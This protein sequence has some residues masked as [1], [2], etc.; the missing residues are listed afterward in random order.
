[1][2]GLLDKAEKAAE[3]V[4]DAN[5]DHT[6]ITTEGQLVV[7]GPFVEGSGMDTTNLMFQL[8][9]VLGLIVTLFL[10]FF[11]SGSTIWDDLF[12]PLLFVFWLL[13]NGKSFIDKEIIPLQL[14]VS[15]VVFLLVSGATAGVSIVMDSGAGV[16]IGS[17]ELDGDDDTLDVSLFGP[18][19]LAYTLS[20][21]VDDVEVHSVDGQINIDRSNEK[22]DLDDFWAGNAQDM[23]GVDKVEYMLKVT[24]DRGEDSYSFDDIMNREVDTGFVTAT[25]VFTTD[26]DG[27]REYTGIE[28]EMILGM[29]NPNADFD[30]DNGAFTG[31]T[32]QPIASD[33]DVTVSVKYNGNA[34]YTYST[35]SIEEGTANGYGDFWFDWVT[36]PGTEAGNLARDDFYQ[37]D[38]C[39]TF[40]VQIVNE[41]GETHT[42]SSSRIEFFW[43]DNEGSSSTADDQNA[44]GC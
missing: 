39:Y 5:L 35:V 43:D 17:I 1:M 12:L 14:V 31:S 30:Y 33:L 38:G 40:E 20:V 15:G 16:S 27:A 32:P 44:K 25:E 28:V 18:S 6:I 42:D 9:A 37:G 7:E 11:V 2:S 4:I 21:Y 36:M 26:S 41:L 3:D 13:F 8:G 34:V 19:G 24:S 22:I 29:G 23:N 10:T